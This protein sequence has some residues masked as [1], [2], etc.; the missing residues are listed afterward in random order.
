MYWRPECGVPIAP[1][2]RQETAEHEVGTSLKGNV[3]VLLGRHGE[4]FEQPDYHKAV[5]LSVMRVSCP[6]SGS[7]HLES[8]TEARS[9]TRAAD[10][11]TYCTQFRHR[12]RHWCNATVG[13]VRPAERLVSEPG[14]AMLK[15]VML[16]QFG[17]PDSSGRPVAP[18]AFVIIG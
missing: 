13:A 11:W 15:N 6:G 7:W 18:R 2:V 9:L 16:N 12:Y 14:H 17:S 10:A 1:I 8:P 5:W 4:I 3:V